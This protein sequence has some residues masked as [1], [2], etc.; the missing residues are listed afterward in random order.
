MSLPLKVNIVGSNTS[1]TLRFGPTMSCS[2]ACKQIKDKIGEGGE[3]HGLFQ[4][5]SPEGKWPSRWLRPDR[6]LQFYDLK[7]N[8]EIDYKKK[9]RAAKIRLLDGS[10]RTILIDD[11]ASVADTVLLIGS[12]IKLSAPEEFGLQISRQPGRWLISAQTLLEQGAQDTDELVLKKRFFVTDDMVGKDDPVQLHMVY[13]QARDHVLDG[14]HA[15]TLDESIL[16]ASLQCQVDL[17]NF[18]AAI[19]KPGFLKLHEVLPAVVL[20]NKLNKPPELEKRILNE[21]KKHVG[22]TEVAAKYRYVQ[23]CRSLRTYG[24]TYFECSQNKPGQ[25]K[26]TPLMIGVS[27]SKISL[28]EPTSKESVKDWKVEWMKRWAASPHSLT[29]DFGE[30]EEDFVVINTEMAEEVSQLISGYIDIMFKKSKDQGVMVDDDGAQTGGVE[31]LGR[32]RGQASSGYTSSVTGG[33]QALH[34]KVAVGAAQSR[35]LAIRAGQG[36]KQQI[37][38]TDIPSAIMSISERIEAIPKEANRTTS[39][40]TPKQWSEQLSTNYSAL[41]LAASKLMDSMNSG[42]GLDRNQMNNYAREIA[43]AVGNMLSSARNASSNQPDDDMPLFDAAKAVSEAIKNLLQA[44]QDLS[45]NPND[46]V[47]RETWKAA[48]ELLKM[49]GVRMESASKGSLVDDGAKRLL[50]ESARAVAAA[51]EG[52]YLDAESAA[53]KLGPAQRDKVLQAAKLLSSTGKA[54]TQIAEMLTPVMMSGEAKGHVQASAGQLQKMAAALLAAAKESGIDPGAM[55][56]LGEAARRVNEALAQLLSASATAEERLDAQD[57]EFANSANDILHG[58]AVMLGAKGKPNVM[59]DQA[60]KILAASGKLIQATKKMATNAPDDAT[61]NRL[62]ACAKRVADATRSLMNSANTASNSPNDESAWAELT[63]SSRTLGEATRLLVGDAGKDTALKALRT[64]AKRA[65]ADTTAL[66]T[67]AQ[68]AAISVR[69][70]PEEQSLLAAARAAAEALKNLISA[71]A[72]ATQNPDDIVANQGLTEGAKLIGPA[73]FGLVTAAK[74]AVPRME[75]EVKRN[76]L[77]HA[78][79]DAGTSVKTMLESMNRVLAV[80]GVAEIEEALELFE[81]TGADIES[82]LMFAE[83][84]GVKAAA[85]T[86]RDT[87]MEALNAGVKSLAAATKEI[88]T[89][90]DNTQRLGGASKHLAGAVA[91]TVEAAKN[92][93]GNTQS[94]AAQKQILSSAQYLNNEATKLAKSARAVVE[95]GSDPELFSILSKSVKETVDALQ[96]LI[97]SSKGTDPGALETDEALKILREQMTRLQNRPERSNPAGF[98]AAS[99]ELTGAVRAFGAA[100]QHVSNTARSNPIALGA[101]VR[102]AAQTIVPFVNGALKTVASCDDESQAQ[103][104]LTAVAPTA[105]CL[106]V[107]LTKA[108]IVASKPD[109]Q[110]TLSELVEASKQMV[111]LVKRVTNAASRSTPAQRQVTL[112]ADEIGGIIAALGNL[113]QEAIRGNEYEA[114]AAYT[115]ALAAST[116]N[117]VK[118]ATGAANDDELAASAVDLTQKMQQVLAAARAAA[119]SDQH[120]PGAYNPNDLSGEAEQLINAARNIGNTVGQLVQVTSDIVHNKKQKA[121]AQPQVAAGAKAVTNAILALNAASAYLKPGARDVA[122]AHEKAQ[123]ASNDLQNASLSAAIGLLENTAPPGK[124]FQEMQESMVGVAKEIAGAVK[125]FVVASKGSPQQTGAAARTLGDLMTKIQNTAKATASTIGDQQRQQENLEQ[126]KVVVDSVVALTQTAKASDPKALNDAAEGSSRAIQEFLD[127]LKGGVMGMREVDEA[128]QRIKNEVGRLASGNTQKPAQGDYRQCQDNLQSIAKQIAGTLNNLAR[129][130]KQ[131]PDDLGRAATTVA[132]TIPNLIEGALQTAAAMP[133]ISA[134]PPLLNSTKSIATGAAAMINDAKQVASDPNNTDKSQ[135]LSNAFN[136]MTNSIRDFIKAVKEG[137]VGEGMVKQAIDALAKTMGS[138]DQA[139]LYAA[140]GQLDIEPAVQSAG[141]KAAR[142]NLVNAAKQIAG[143]ATNLAKS[144]QGTPEQLGGA[145]KQLAG[146]VENLATAT[147]N[148]AALSTDLEQQKQLIESAR[149]VAVS[150][151]SMLVACQENAT[152]QSLAQQAGL[153]SEALKKLMQT[154]QASN[155]SSDRSLAALDAAKAAVQQNLGRFQQGNYAGA[156]GASTDSVVEAAKAIAEAV[157]DMMTACTGGSSDELINAANAAS[158]TTSQLLDNT[159]GASKQDGVKPDVFQKANASAAAVA[160]AIISFFDAAKAQKDKS[161]PE[162]QRK[163]SELA[164]VVVDRINE[165][166]DAATQLPGGA[167]AEQIFRGGDDLEAMAEKELLNA[168]EV[169]QAAA[170]A[171]LKAK[172]RRKKAQAV[173]IQ[174]EDM[175]EYVLD[176][177]QAIAQATGNLVMAATV[178]QKELVAQGRTAGRASESVYKKDPAWA[179]GLISAAKSVAGSVQLLVDAAN[180]AAQGKAKESELVAAA[181]GVAAATARLV[182]ASRTKA[183]PMSESLGKLGNCAKSVAGATAQLVQAAKDAGT[184]G[185]QAEEIDYTQLSAM[186]KKRLEM[187]K[188]AS[189]EALQKQLEQQEK[190]L[191]D[192]HRKEY[193]AAR[194]GAKQ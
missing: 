100:A 175:V 164:G 66:L 36:Q 84:S 92:V 192:F 123:E 191:K 8:D 125:D 97:A 21:Y 182:S 59:T 58:T 117:L 4:K 145:A 78:A 37:V 22:S 133:E 147:T 11:S 71:T 47:A 3:D 23:L 74:G 172:K 180:N 38:I 134:R 132:N 106:G 131:N 79:N 93:A 10:N 19:H 48:Q 87:S 33:H 54:T 62:L 143:A 193:E 46:P 163:L 56:Y 95:N 72:H 41:A 25:K 76:N 158:S 16:F 40:L 6:T 96:V 1:R 18:N 29:L 52:M 91:Q 137:N 174:G 94:R 65:A 12:K 150:S 101:A 177:A 138:L 126:A 187:E 128:T 156:Q 146:V 105:Q 99:E 153:I 118:G 184:D 69:G 181:R 103:Q 190:M 90:K 45:A 43:M 165:A 32:I 70:L 60:Q 176:A 15:C 149:Q 50:L 7:A 116:T 189:L 119:S 80:A 108:R 2:E 55:E 77:I 28:V 162:N 166:V 42:Q 113:S 104:I 39:N 178:V 139:S 122:V 129:V 30:Y 154:S 75:D 120:H 144:T 17:G 57:R 63:A 107:I 44:S 114:L 20:N 135:Q 49:A 161:T 13:V 102:G 35:A 168:A 67:A 89:L 14:T 111:E 157:S 68:I 148:V 115:K 98:P 188:L 167:N 82:A 64:N 124:T 179:K 142:D 127:Y 173:K 140:A 27:V 88:A 160:Q 136:S 24:I 155:A 130:A 81:A 171:L 9:H 185:E 186:Q 112:A 83:T 73:V 159:R 109:N 53:S 5:A 169:I 152:P 31:S 183:D 34:G 194:R 110:Q 86:T 170:A 26:P 121:Q 151:E 141:E 85:G 51:T 61:K